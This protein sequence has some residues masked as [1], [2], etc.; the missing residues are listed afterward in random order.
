MNEPKKALSA[1][2]DVPSP[3]KCPSVP[4]R[5]RVEHPA[6]LLYVEWWDHHSQDEWCADEDVDDAPL[7][8]KTV[9][10]LHSEND[11]VLVV[12]GNYSGENNTKPY[13]N[14]MTILQ[15]TIHRRVPLTKPAKPKNKKQDAGQNNSRPS[16]ARSRT[17]D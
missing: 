12:Y 13:S 9:G 1:V 7:L 17:R 2:L 3:T 14:L 10:W 6:T 16:I 4:K 5:V 11:K 8:V 15:G